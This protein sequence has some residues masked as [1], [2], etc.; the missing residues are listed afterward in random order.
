ME[1]GER[2]TLIGLIR[3]LDVRSVLEIGRWYGGCHEF[4]L[5]YVDRY[6]SVDPVELAVWDP[7]VE[8]HTMTSDEYFKQHNDRFDLAVVDGDHDAKAAGRDLENAMRRCSV[9][10]LHDTH[11]GARPG[12]EDALRKVSV[13]YANL[14]FLRCR[15]ED[16]P[17]EPGGTWG[18]L[19]L[20]IV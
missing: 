16:M 9:V 2:T 1:P 14:D 18:G 20:V 5:P 15:W 3:L 10:L 8:A 7:R 12:Y 17:W 11:S 19:G 4:V 6:V 13:R